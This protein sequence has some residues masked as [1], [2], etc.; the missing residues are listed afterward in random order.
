MAALMGNTHPLETL[1]AKELRYGLVLV[2]FWIGGLKFTAYEAHGVYM[3]ASNSPL[4]SW[5]ERCWECE[6]FPRCWESSRSPSAPSSR[7][8]P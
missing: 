1:G 7:A 3:H 6:G 8:V 4:L 2:L 5:A